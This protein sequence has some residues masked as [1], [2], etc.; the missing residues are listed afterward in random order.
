[1]LCPVSSFGCFR[2]HQG[3]KSDFIRHIAQEAVALVRDGNADLFLGK[4]VH[5]FHAEFIACATSKITPMPLYR[6]VEDMSSE[7]VVDSQRVEGTNGCLKKQMKVAPGIALRLLSARTTVKTMFPSVRN[8]VSSTDHPSNLRGW[9]G[10]HG[11]AAMAAARHEFPAFKAR[12][13]ALVMDKSRWS[14][15]DPTAVPLDEYAPLPPQEALTKRHRATAS[16]TAVD[17][18]FAAEMLVALK[19]MLDHSGTSWQPDATVAFELLCVRVANA[20]EPH[21]SVASLEEF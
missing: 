14:L 10:H 8:N 5:V 11:V 7:W 20:G 13:E 16:K 15:L 12:L 1:M 4:L 17:Q 3:S 2:L 19:D 18:H 9:E 21:E 6:F